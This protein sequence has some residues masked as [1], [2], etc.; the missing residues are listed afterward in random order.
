MGKKII[1][2]HKSGLLCLEDTTTLSGQGERI[3]MRQGCL[4][5]AKMLAAQEGAFMHGDGFG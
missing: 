4:I 5:V 2:A 1:S 3:Q